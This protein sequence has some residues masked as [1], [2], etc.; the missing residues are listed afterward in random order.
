MIQEKQNKKP[1]AYCTKGLIKNLYAHY[2]LINS[3][4]LFSALPSAVLL[5]PIGF[6]SPFPSVLN[7]P[8]FIPNSF[9]KQFLIALALFLESSILASSD[10]SLS[11]WPTMSTFTLSFSFKTLAISFTARTIGRCWPGWPPRRRSRR[12]RARRSLEPPR[13]KT[14]VRLASALKIAA[15]WRRGRQR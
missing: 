10:P 12:L 11:V 4:R 8:W 9:T 15:R 3:T 13:S 14:P 5:S 1:F 2:C 7:R 6:I